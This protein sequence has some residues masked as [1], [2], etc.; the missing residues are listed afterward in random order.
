MSADDPD[1]YIC[2]ECGAY[3]P[4]LD[5]MGDPMCD[6]G[7]QAFWPCG[8]PE[9]QTWASFVARQR[10]RRLVAESKVAE[11]SERVHQLERVIVDDRIKESC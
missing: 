9:G 11:L 5:L 7:S 8:T 6:C 4:Y 2:Q 1:P 10:E 3:F